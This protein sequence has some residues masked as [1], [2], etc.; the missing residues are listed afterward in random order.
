MFWRYWPKLLIL[1]VFLWMNIFS[2]S[3]NSFNYKSDSIACDT[4][5]SVRNFDGFQQ[6][7]A[8]SLFW[9][10][11]LLDSTIIPQNIIGFILHRDLEEIDTITFTGEETY[12]YFDN[13]SN[14]YPAYH[15]YHI[16]T[17]YDLTTCGLPGQT[18]Q[19]IS[20][21][22]L[23]FLPY[24][25]IILS[26]WEDWS[27][28]SFDPNLWEHDEDWS[29]VGNYGN[30]IPS[31]AFLDSSD[32]AYSQ[33]IVSYWID[34]VTHPGTEDPYID[35]DYYLEFDIELNNLLT[36]YTDYL[37]IAVIN[38]TG[39]HEIQQYSTDS[40]NFA[41]L[42]QHINITELARG[43][44][45][46]IAFM[47]HGDIG[48]NNTYW[49]IDNIRVYRQ[50]N[51]PRD[52]HWAV[53]G[54]V[55]A[56]SPP[57]PHTPTKEYKGK[58]LQGYNIYVKYGS[59]YEFYTFTTDTFHLVD[60][61][62]WNAFYVTARYEDCEPAS[63]EL[64]G[65]Q[66]I[67]E[68]PDKTNISVYPNPCSEKLQ[69]SSDLPIRSLQLFNA[70]GEKILEKAANSNKIAINTSHLPNGIYFLKITTVS[71]DHLKKLVFTD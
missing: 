8:V 14:H 13:L 19:S 25:T 48:L 66:S 21:D 20:T 41:W 1:F 51:P 43:N 33:K 47:A 29:I 27:T 64:F 52:L 31:A 16:I 7:A 35:G 57:L 53:P 45:I 54:E 38:S 37:D 50:C 70:R 4:F 18:G 44:F 5:P 58:G 22:T 60:I 61:S 71:S 59:Q 68:V 30:P 36:G 12:S 67:P 11:P 63:N 24:Q 49:Y 9:D 69:V 10:A 2:F 55:M 42:E 32:S 3:Q 6:W 62:G 46:Q 40:G 23:E 34:C 17:L 39:W 15:Y 26:F 65:P 28:G 56:W